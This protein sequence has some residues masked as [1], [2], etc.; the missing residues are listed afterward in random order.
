MLAVN[1]EED[2]ELI[3]AIADSEELE[4]FRC[5]I[6]KDL[7]DYK[8]ETF[9]RRVHFIGAFFHVCYV[10]AMY[11]Y[12]IN[13]FLIPPTK[14]AD[15]TLVNP[16]PNIDLLIAMLVCLFYP[17]NYDGTQLIKGGF[18]Y[19]KDPW[20]YVDMLHIALGY[21]NIYLQWS[22]RTWDIGSK[23]VFIAVILLTLIKTFFFMR[24]VMSFSYIV[25]MIFSVCY[26]LRVFLLFFSILMIKFSAVFNIITIQTDPEYEKLPYA[27]GSMFHT[28]RVALGDFQFGILQSGNLSDRQHWMLWIVWLFMV[29]ISSLIFLNFII[30]EVSNSYS[31]INVNIDA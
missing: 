24:I 12:I 9:A 7:L 13:V 4:I 3:D 28:I 25:T 6:I 15:G 19:F 29:F 16:P 21:F 18:S 23:I 30:A 8:W 2:G 31:K 20:N 14:E 26:D 17:L 27:L 1:C 5:Q 11:W 10:V 22:G